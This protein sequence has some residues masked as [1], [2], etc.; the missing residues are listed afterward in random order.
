MPTKGK[1]RTKSKKNIKRFYPYVLMT[2][3][4]L[5]TFRSFIGL[6]QYGFIPWIAA[7]FNPTATGKNDKI[8]NFAL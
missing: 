4:G 7:I 3:L 8:S 2:D 1:K 6:R 5:K